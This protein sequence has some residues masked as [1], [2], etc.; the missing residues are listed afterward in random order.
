[1]RREKA[2]GAYSTGAF[3]L[4]KTLTVAPFQVVQVLAFCVAVYFM[5]GLGGTA[6]QFLIF[7]AV[8]LMFTLT[9]ETLGLISAFVSPNSKVRAR[10][11]RV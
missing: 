6:S 8:T 3:F 7:Y 10:G 1:M 11:A 5:A 9:S 2:S 4:A